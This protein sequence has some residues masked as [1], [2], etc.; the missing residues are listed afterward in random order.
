MLIATDIRRAYETKIE[1]VLQGEQVGLRL[2][3]LIER[4]QAGDQGG[5]RED[6]L[7]ALVWHLIGTHRLRF[8][9]TRKL[10]LTPAEHERQNDL[11]EREE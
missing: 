8:S 5:L 7:V 2:P 9:A 1:S 11:E 6:L 10:S 4:V 3:E